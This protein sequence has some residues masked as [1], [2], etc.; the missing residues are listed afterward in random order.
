MKYRIFSL[1]ILAAALGFTGCIETEMLVRVNKDG[2]GTIRETV[3][4]KRAAVESIKEMT[5][6]FKQSAAEEGVK[7]EDADKP[8]ELFTEEEIRSKSEEMGLN[9][10]YVSHELIDNDES[11]GY[12]AEYAFDDIN[13]VQVSQNPTASLPEVSGGETSTEEDEEVVMFSFAAGNPATLTIRPPQMN[14]S[15]DED[16]IDIEETDEENSDEED[17]EEFGGAEQMKELFRDMRILVQVEVDGDVT[18]TNATYVDGR[19]V[20]IMDIEFNTFIDNDDLLEQLEQIE[21][22]G[23]AAAKEFF[24]S[25]PG[26]RV[27]TADEISVTFD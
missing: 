20:T 24:K 7:S 27:E 22:K 15:E 8:F 11:M 23:P 25:I 14:E 16:E 26:I 5:E 21:A 9:V 1:V 18:K 13:T 6:Q 3:A 12:I 4:M 2:S 17:G 10:R 19:V